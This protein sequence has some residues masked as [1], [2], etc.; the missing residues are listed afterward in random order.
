[1]KFLRRL[2]LSL[3]T[4]ILLW[5]SWPPHGFAFLSFFAFVPLFWVSE[6]LTNEKV[7][8]PFFSGMGYSYI[9]FVVWNAC[10]TWWVW[11]STPEGA[12]AMILLNSLFMSMV[13]GCWQRFRSLNLPWITAPVC[14]VA[15]WCS[16]EFLHLN[17]DI[18]WPWLNLGNIFSSCTEFVQWY[19]ITGAFGGTIWILV[20]NFV[21]VFLLK[22]LRENRKKSII[23]ATALLAWI[24][25]PAAGSLIRYSTYQLPNDKTDKSIEVVVVQQ[26]TDP[27][28]EQYMMS[29][30]EHTARLLSVAGPYITK[31]TDLVL[32]SESAM[33]NTVLYDHF[34]NG[35]GRNSQIYSGLEMFDT[36]ILTHSDLNFIFGASICRYYD[37]K[38][39]ETAREVPAAIGVSYIDYYNASVCYNRY[40]VIGTYYKSKLVPGVEKMP[41]PKIFGFLEKLAIDLGGTS[42]SLGTDS[43]QRCFELSD[44]QAIVGCPICYESA[45]GEHFGKFVRNGAQVMGVITNDAWWGETPG[46]T[47]HFLF[48]KLRA[49]ETRRSVMRAANTGT[50]AFIDE[51]GDVHQATKYATRTAIHQRVYLNDNLTFYTRHGDYL[52]RFF[53]VLAGII[54]LFAIT[55][56]IRL[57]LRSR[58]QKNV[59]DQE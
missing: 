1:M 38:A 15:F 17:W 45:Y 36:T 34:I 50:S 26:N 19:E 30:A 49:V 14:F 47:Q 41:Y 21:A 32:C 10:T 52:A 25:L 37:H 16:W 29:N 7:H 5:L 31:K 2:L 6:E 20:A 28:E 9:S 48:S 53:A 35:T 39:S 42:G 58:K 13:F 11:N 51:R 59:L 24:V 33:A 40:G 44:G 43:V 23:A 55:W 12:I 56:R 54:V 46:H 27:W 4:G 18:T 57:I 3:L 8:S 22:N